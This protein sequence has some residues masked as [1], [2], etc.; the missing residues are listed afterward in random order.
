ME[1]PTPSRGGLGEPQPDQLQT[2]LL[3]H[4]LRAQAR[5]NEVPKKRVRK[6]E[7]RRARSSRRNARR[8][9]RRRAYRLWRGAILREW[10][11]HWKAG[12]SRKHHAVPPG[13]IGT[14]GK[15]TTPNSQPLKV[16][17]K[18]KQHVTNKRRTQNMS[19][20]APQV[21][22]GGRIPWTLTRWIARHSQRPTH[23]HA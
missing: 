7:A 21:P 13:L 6:P 8:A 23:L 10:P 15:A 2:K 19:A 5:G 18:A 12:T 16:R 9:S 11:D 3:H 22:D 20:A 14:T 4:A 17:G 1:Q